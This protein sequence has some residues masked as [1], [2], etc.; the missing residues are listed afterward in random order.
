MVE[1]KGEGK[2]YPP[3]QSGRTP[4]PTPMEPPFRLYLATCLTVNTRRVSLCI[5][6]LAKESSSVHLRTLHHG[7]VDQSTVCVYGLASNCG[8]GVFVTSCLH[9]SHDELVG[10]LEPSFTYLVWRLPGLEEF[11]LEVM[12]LVL[13]Q[14]SWVLC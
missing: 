2:F 10:E 1:V 13:P 5:P 14:C 7:G 8:S 3:T 9:G 4:F 12:S 6:L 11:V